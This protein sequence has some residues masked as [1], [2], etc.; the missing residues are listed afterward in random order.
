M[1]HTDQKILGISRGWLAVL[2]GAFFYCYQYILRVSPNVMHDGLMTDFGIEADTFGTIISFYSWSYAGVQIPLGIALDRF[3]PGKIISI[4]AL[5]CAFSCFLFSST[6]NIYIASLSM[7]L[8][9]LGSASG[10]LGS[11]KL[12]TI[13]FPPQHLAKIIA[14]IMIFGTLGAGI[15][16]T[17]LSMLID[18]VGRQATFTILGSVGGLL[19][20]TIYA[21]VGR[22]SVPSLYEPTGNIFDGL[23]EVAMSPQAW[24]I[25]LYGMFMYAPITIMGIAWGVPFLQSMYGIDAKIGATFIT[26]MFIGAA[27]E[28]PFSQQFQT[29]LNGV[30]SL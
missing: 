12:G 26:V 23:K 25:S 3:G 13:W 24:L 27:V 17:P 14:L 4:A 11:I 5:I 20:L 16:G 10:F 22:V 30:A 9:G 7:F 29:K 6:T 15:G 2:C 18:A 1:K 8:M 19:S 21:I 28:A